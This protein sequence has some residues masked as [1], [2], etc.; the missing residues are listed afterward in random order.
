[1][2]GLDPEWRGRLEVRPPRERRLHL[3]TAVR[4]DWEPGDERIVLEHALTVAGRVVDEAGR[5]VA[6]ALV[7]LADLRMIGATRPP[8][9][10]RRTT[11]RSG[12]APCPKDMVTLRVGRP[13]VTDVAAMTTVTV[14]A[15][16]QD[17]VLV[18]KRGAGLRIV[19]ENW[20]EAQI[21]WPGRPRFVLLTEVGGRGV[22]RRLK[23]EE[24]GTVQA[25]GLEPGV[26]Y[27]LWGRSRQPTECYVHVVGVRASPEPLVVR[28]EKGGSLVGRA[29]CPEGVYLIHAGL[30]GPGVHVPGITGR[31]PGV[32]HFD[33][34]PP[35][36]WTVR[37]AGA[38]P[39]A[40]IQ[41]L[42]REYWSAE[43]E[44][45]AG[46]DLDLDLVRHEVR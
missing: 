19:I 32:F 13:G 8:P 26:E 28:I 36:V 30:Y 45:A 38:R 9:S 46:D 43:C 18:V 34:V 1:M 42:R 15:G 5:G 40:S 6:R 12:S 11:V 35:G 37:V 3:L 17:L 24:D 10:R 2:A 21:T 22:R 4:R 27:V 33:G 16:R 14:A 23:I 29:T 31:V 44:A 39:G 41:E 7:R 20:S 25:D